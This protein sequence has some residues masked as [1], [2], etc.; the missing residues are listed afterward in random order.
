MK[1]Y[2]LE[3]EIRPTPKTKLIYRAWSFLMLILTGI[4]IYMVYETKLI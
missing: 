2:G 1:P 3:A 4:L